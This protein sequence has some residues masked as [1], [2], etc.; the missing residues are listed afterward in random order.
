MAKKLFSGLFSAPSAGNAI[1]WRLLAYDWR[2]DGRAAEFGVDLH[3]SAHAPMR[4][5]PVL[6]FASCAYPDG[7][8]AKSTAAML[9][10]ALAFVKSCTKDL[11]AVIAG[12]IETDAELQY[13]IYLPSTAEYERMKAL[14]GE[15]KGA[16]G[17]EI[18]VGGRSE[19]DWDSYFSVLYPDEAKM[20]TIRNGE[21][22]DELFKSGDSEAPRRL[23]LL[24]A[25]PTEADCGAF[26]A[27]ALDEGFATGEYKD[28]SDGELPCGV[29]VHRICAM[30]KWD[31]DA[32]TVH[33]IRLAEEHGGKLLY[34][35][36][37][38]VPRRL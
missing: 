30:K 4:S 24:L 14:A 23:N 36:C 9:K 13:Y 1:E 11:N 32:V 8:E 22:I 35:D 17:V 33:A 31:V 34:W 7:A 5:H 10:K 6:A 3:L 16:D 2:L 26:A 29:V 18:M 38:I 21:I 27:K 37:P 25:F 12:Y 15:I 19:P 28:V 20:Q